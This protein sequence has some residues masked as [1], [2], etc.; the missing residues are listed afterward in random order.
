M[1]GL[2]KKTEDKV[3]TTAEATYLPAVD[4]VEGESGYTIYAD[5]PGAT[6]D[7]VQVSYESGTLTLKATAAAQKKTETAG[8]IH[9]EFRFADYER[10]FRVGDDV[11][12]DAIAAEIT[13]G[14][15]KVSLPRKAS[16]K[17]AIAVTAK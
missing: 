10:T 16:A 4:V 7:S 1:F 12:A 6:K 8:L 3:A 13:E 17:K 11:D 14:V 2:D 15:L 5:V 9:R